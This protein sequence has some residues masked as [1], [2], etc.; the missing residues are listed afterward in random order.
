MRKIKEVLRLRYGF[1]LSERDIASSCQ[2]TR[3]TVANYLKRAAA[4]GLTWPQAGELGDAELEAR[5][6]PVLAAPAVTRHPLPDFEDIHRQLREHRGVNLTLLQ[7]WLEYRKDH[8]DGYHYTQYC[9]H[10]RRWR[11]KLDY[12]LRGEHRAGEKL[13]VDYTSGLAIVD[14][15]TGELIPT[16]LF[17]AVWGASNYTYAEASLTQGL[18]DWTR[19]HVRAFEYFGCVAKVVV[20]DNL[21]SGVKSAC[22]YEPELNPTYAD[23]ASHY[24]CAVLPAKSKRP[25]YKAKVEVGVLI[26]QRWILAVLRQRTFFSLAEMNTA[27][28]E[29]LEHLNT[30]QMRRVGKSRR[31]LFETLDRPAAGP[32]PERPYEYAEWRKATVNIDY[33]IEVDGHYYS[34]PFS[35]LREKLEVRLTVTTVE[36]LRKGERVAAHSRSGVRGGHSTLKEH[37]PPEHRRYAEWSPSRFIEWAGRTGESTA[38]VVEKILASRTY[39]EQAYRACLGILRLG[40]EYDPA[41]VE[42]A[43][44]RA[45]EFNTCSYRSLRTILASGLDTQASAEK[46]PPPLPLHDNIRGPE[47]YN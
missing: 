34:V 24:G 33:H 47:F 10:Y 3:G 2:V 6:F 13:F 23:L 15:L 30:R 36:V 1:G 42:A 27:I 38:R 4:A 25:R 43:A 16:E 8:P 19:S 44:R 28:R 26:A 20:P 45:L 7:L 14:A 39:P 37:M 22:F 21:K 41:R 12:C 35:L 17:V 32:L 5:L 9:E 11:G 46:R 31:E 18:P 29:L 40:R